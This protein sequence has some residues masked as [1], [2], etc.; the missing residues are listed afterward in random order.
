MTVQRYHPT[1]LQ[2]FFSAVGLALVFCNR[3][4]N[5]RCQRDSMDRREPETHDARRHGVGNTDHF[6]IFCR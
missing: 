2:S 6:A 5:E 3:G 4:R 1:A